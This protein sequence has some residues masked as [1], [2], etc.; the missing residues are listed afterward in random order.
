MM[1]R[2]MPRMLMANG[3]DAQ[4]TEQPKM[5]GFPSGTFQGNPGGQNKNMSRSGETGRDNTMRA[6]ARRLGEQIKQEHGMKGV[7]KYVMSMR[8]YLPPQE[9]KALGQAFGLDV[10]TSASGEREVR[11]H[12]QT[13]DNR[14]PVQQAAPQQNLTNQGSS[15]NPMLQMLTSMVGGG[16]PN[17]PF[18]DMINGGGGIN[19]LML[20][21]LLGNMN[22]PQ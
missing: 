16:I 15:M 11:Q 6:N 1:P 21:Q 9:W 12:Q 18:G 17:L 20:A 10:D 7:R 8:E 3:N 5:N 13:Q 19:P 4:K 2:Y 14:Q 22:K